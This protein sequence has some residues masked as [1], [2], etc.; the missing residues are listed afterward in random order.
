[1]GRKAEVLAYRGFIYPG[2]SDL[3]DCV[4]ADLVPDSDLM[5]LWL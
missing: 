5:R 2:Q 4:S 3:Y 1:M